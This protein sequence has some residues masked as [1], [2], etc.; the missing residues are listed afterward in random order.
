MRRW[1]LLQEI[2]VVCGISVGLFSVNPAV[3]ALSLNTSFT[4][5]GT[6]TDNLFFQNVDTEE[7]FGTLVGPDVTLLFENADIVIGATYTGRLSLFANNTDANRYN[8]NADIILDLPFLTKQYRGLTVTIDEN[9]SFTPQLDAF[10]L[11]EAENASRT[12]GA[13]PGLGGSR[14]SGG[15]TGNSAGAGSAG[16]SSGVGGGSLGGSGVGGTGGTQGVFTRRAS[17]FLN[18]AGLTLGYTWSPRVNTTLAY[19]NQYRHFFSKGF[20]D[21]LTHTGTFSAPFQVTE[22]IS[23]EP[24]YAY[25]Q[26][27]FLGKST[28]NT[29]ADRIISHTARLGLTHFFT[30]TF[31]GTIS[32]GMSFVKQVGATEMI[33]L[34]GGGT[35]ERELGSKYVG[36]FVGHAILDKSFQRGTMSLSGSQAIGSGGGLASQASRTRTVTGRGSYLLTPRMETFASVGWAEN[37][38]I[39]GDAF[40]STTYR[41]QAGLS[42]SF[43]SW[44]YGD[45]SYSRIDQRSKGTAASDVVVNQGFLSLTAIAD[46]WFLYR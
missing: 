12:P 40:D 8:Q 43:Y 45:V 19:A 29:T 37:V 10:A 11:S 42:Y 44:L 16:G 31:S 25:R 5:T 18:N 4:T 24:S 28:A 23:V 6:Y 27:D 38:S 33:T 14:S 30:P 41:A 26:T 34:A 35:Q 39:D 36:S 22:F 17:A 2:A 3:A 9:M 46:P 21:S 13:N 1:R 7:D 32:G 20:Q 15:T